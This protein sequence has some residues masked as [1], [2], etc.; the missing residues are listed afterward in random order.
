MNTLILSPIGL[1]NESM[2][3]AN[4]DDGLD[5][6]YEV[7]TRSRST[8]ASS[9]RSSFKQSSLEKM[10]CDQVIALFESE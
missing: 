6:I 8:L 5:F 10:S 1:K 4:N 2:E 3:F 9:M 7:D